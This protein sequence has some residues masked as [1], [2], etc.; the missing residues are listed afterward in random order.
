MTP[1]PGTHEKVRSV[2]APFVLLL[3]VIG[4]FW[5]IL[6]I[7]QYSWLQS[8]DLAWQVL[9]WFQFQAVQFHRH[10]FPLWDPFQFAGQSLIGQVQP[11]LA[12]PLNWILFS[13]PLRD[14]HIS[15]HY[16]SWYY[17]AIHY[18]AALFCYGLCR[19]LG[20]SRLAS[21][22][23][24]VSFA[25]GG[26]IGNVGYPQIVNGAAWGPLVFLFL[27]RALRGVRPYTSAALSGTF[28]GVCWL[29]GHHIVPI[30]LSLAALGV[31]LYSL[32]EGDRL[33]RHIFALAAVFIAF[34][35]MA[36]AFQ[37]WPTISYAHTA[38]RWVGSQHDPIAWNQP[39][40]YTVHQQYSLSPKYLLGV[41]I[42]GFDDGVATYVGVVALALSGLALLRFW[43]TKEVR[44]LFGTGI[45]GLLFALGSSD[46]FHGILYSIVPMLDKAREPYNAIYLFHF[47][48]AVLLAFGMDALMEQSARATLR[49]LALILLGFGTVAFLIVFGVFIAHNQKWTGDDRVMITVLA[50]FA[51]A[52]LV[53]RMSL[54]T[55]VRKGIPILIV[56]L[57]LVEIGNGAFLYLPNKE[58]A[59]RNVYLSH[60]DDT[61]QV[62]EFL[63]HQP[64]PVRAWTSGDDVPFNFGDWYGIDTLFGYAPGV[65]SSYYR[66][67]AY[68]LRGRQ[69]FA[70]AYTVSR[71]PLFADQKEVFRDSNGL[72]VYENPDV[73]P[74]VWTVHDAVQVRDANDA[75]RHLQD[76][77]FDIRTRTFSYSRPPALEQCSGDEVK[78]ST[79]GTNW[80]TAV[81][82]MKCKGIVVTSENN[83]PGWTASLDGHSTPV[84]DA[85]TTLQGVVVGPGPHKIELRYRPL[86]VQAGAT[87]T[88]LAFLGAFVLWF[89]TPK[90]QTPDA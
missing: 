52:G 76:P 17:M 77:A 64:A 61:K 74:R 63:R 89:T 6:L 58:E 82:E 57:Y 84:Y 43:Q 66:I 37:M 73:Q 45:A 22:L 75:R 48:I 44:L 54:A 19:D 47:A 36:G 69:I 30:F 28:L 26:Y 42:P 80:S 7:N 20:R 25:L 56:A 41:L 11:G 34:A 33:N 49:H 4:F 85:Y 67:E 90:E 14:G 35:A 68:T 70:T 40:P 81:V 31:W 10:A 1:V 71:K 18:L 62:A 5:K 50:S 78:S 83:A 13:L 15:L 53:Y 65:P 79:R 59:N 12:Y 3:I 46:V 55:T 8:P 87:A 29:S 24:G 88:A 16:L 23:A 27:F 39:I 60:L 51:L 9:P 38:V 21:I 72:A 32:L 2:A 86:S